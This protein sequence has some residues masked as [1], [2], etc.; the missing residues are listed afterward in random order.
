M[1]SAFQKEK[2]SHYFRVVL[3]QDRNGVLEV[4]DFREIG[5]SLC[6][7]W[8]FKPDTEEY[9]K[10]INRSIQSWKM[11][12]K[13]F[14]TQGGEANEEHFIEFFEDILKPGNESLY[15][16]WVI[17]MI[18]SI[19][20]SFDVNNDGVI[21]VNEYSDMFMCYHIPIRHSAKAFVKLDR[22]GDDFI[23]KK[24]LMK[25][26]DEFF[27]SSNEKAPG[28]WLFGFWGDKD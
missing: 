4:N 1:L 18:S 5:E 15:K 14:E 8:M 16:S 6:L 24:E 25:A 2:I 17:R 13:Y 19:F 23:T 3:D 22:D 9:N 12:Q 20:D 7:L 10:V 27:R 26:V 21:S 11:F 28:N